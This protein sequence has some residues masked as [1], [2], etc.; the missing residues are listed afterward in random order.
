MKEDARISTSLKRSVDYVST[1]VKEVVLD[2]VSSPPLE[3][4]PVL[5]YFESESEA[6]L[7]S[8]GWVSSKVDR[9]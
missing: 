1:L 7:K 4:T 8:S 6:L 9:P 3:Y 2:P 5:T